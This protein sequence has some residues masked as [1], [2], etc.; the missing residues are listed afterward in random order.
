MFSLQPKLIQ[1]DLSRGWPPVGSCCFTNNLT[2]V[3]YQ[4]STHLS[5]SSSSQNDGQDASHK[6]KGVILYANSAIPAQVS[7]GLSASPPS[8]QCVC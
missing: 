1:L 2:C 4:G 5:Q 3:T 7:A 6:P 8:T